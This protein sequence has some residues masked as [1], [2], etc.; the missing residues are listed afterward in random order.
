[1]T[2]AAPFGLAE[3]L[4][5][6]GRTIPFDYA[7]HFELEGKPG[8]THTDKIT[9]SIEAAFTAVS[10]GYGLVAK[11]LP[12]RF[13]PRP[14][15][16]AAAPGLAAGGILPTSLAQV[17]FGD[18]IA[19]LDGLTTD[20]RDQIFASGLRL[21]PGFAELAL[22]DDGAG[23]VPAGVMSELFQAVAVPTEQIQFTYALFDDGSGREF[24][25]API[26]NTAGLGTADGER[27]F[28]YF[29]R[30]ITFTPHSVIRMEV[31]ELSTVPSDLY[32]SLHGYKV[33]GESGTPTGRQPSPR[34]RRR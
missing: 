14:P 2:F 23:T 16:L 33:L 24:Q 3:P 4:D 30:P 10:I 17:G 32:V 31:S 29:A 34:A 7:F 26:L 28:H 19:A 25:S 18:L 21:T 6:E 12:F 1:M 20:Q 11:A 15:I 5:N 27:P 8:E 22:R 13:G 9:V